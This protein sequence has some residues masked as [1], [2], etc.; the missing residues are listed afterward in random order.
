MSMKFC[1]CILIKW[2]HL[3]LVDFSGSYMKGELG[4]MY[5]AI[6]VTKHWDTYCSLSDRFSFCCFTATHQS[7][8]EI[9]HFSENCHYL[10]ISIIISPLGI[11]LGQERFL[12]RAGWTWK[13]WDVFLFF[14]SSEGPDAASKEL[15]LTQWA[16]KPCENSCLSWSCLE[17]HKPYN[18]LS[19]Y[20][21]AS[22]AGFRWDHDMERRMAG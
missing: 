6:S 18:S 4:P 21:L 3:S 19:W 11:Y 14:S 8:H 15:Y 13:A 10:F 5:Q 7:E 2:T 17:T 1:W 22:V 20:C 9:M 12:D 16:G